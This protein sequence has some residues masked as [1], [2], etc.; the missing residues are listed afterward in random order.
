MAAP[1]VVYGESISV[2]TRPGSRSPRCPP[3]CPVTHRTAEHYKISHPHNTP[4]IYRNLGFNASCLGILVI[5]CAHF[6][7]RVKQ[8]HKS[9]KN[10]VVVNQWN[11]QVARWYEH[12]LVVPQTSS[13]SR[14]HGGR[15]NLRD[16]PSCCAGLGARAE[17]YS[18][19]P[20]SNYYIRPCD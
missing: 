9:A 19:S 18:N 15:P 7:R 1:P 17:W 12:I 10:A 20:Y 8:H 14:Q 16:M 5:T 3:P 13:S 4:T 11:A 2:G 6:I